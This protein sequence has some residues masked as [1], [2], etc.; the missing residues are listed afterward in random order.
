MEILRVTVAE[1][2]REIGIQKAL[3]AHHVDI[4]LQ[5]LTESALLALLGDPVGM[6]HA[7]PATHIVGQA[8]GIPPPSHAPP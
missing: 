8:I 5:F 3:G 4:L 2:F 7:A 6:H 1:R